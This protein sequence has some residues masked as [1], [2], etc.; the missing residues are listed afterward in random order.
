MISNRLFFLSASALLLLSACPRPA[1]LIDEPTKWKFSPD[2]TYK[3]TSPSPSPSLETAQEQKITSSTLAPFR[4]VTLDN[5]D[6]ISDSF[7]LNFGPGSKGFEFA[8]GSKGFDFGPGSKGFN[9]LNL[10]FDIRYPETLTNPS[11]PPFKVQQSALEA[12]GGPKIQELVIEFIRDNELYATATT[13]PLRPVIQVPASF[14]PG[15][16]QLSV[17]LKTATHTQQLSWQQI[18]VSSTAQTVLRVDIFGNTQTRPE[19]L[20]VGVLTKIEPF[21]IAS[22]AP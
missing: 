3:D 7:K 13:I 11:L 16:Y 17:M 18:T 2:D 6:I 4:W 5:G 1:P 12:F 21:P 20:D 19:D 9:A 15:K 8:P 10:R 22:I 14:T